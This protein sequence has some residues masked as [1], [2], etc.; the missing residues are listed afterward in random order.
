MPGVE[1]KVFQGFTACS[2][3]IRNGSSA[4]ILRQIMN[5]PLIQCDQV[6][7]RFL[8]LSLAAW[9]ALISL[10]AAAVTAFL[11]LKGRAQ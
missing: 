4:D 9:N 2:S 5:V 11:L 1:A 7:W 10:P 8:S 6:Q 3:A